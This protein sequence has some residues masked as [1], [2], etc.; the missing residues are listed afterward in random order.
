MLKTEVLSEKARNRYKN[1]SEKEKEAKGIS[2]IQIS[3]EYC[4]K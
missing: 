2:K 4:F 1:L 3:H